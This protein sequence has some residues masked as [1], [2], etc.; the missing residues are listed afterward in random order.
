MQPFMKALR[1]ELLKT[2]KIDLYAD[3]TDTELIA[4]NTVGQ[5][6]T[7]GSE[8]NKKS[9]TRQLKILDGRVKQ[10]EV[11]G[12]FPKV[13]QGDF[14]QIEEA[15]ANFYKVKEALFNIGDFEREVRACLKQLG[16]KVSSIEIPPSTNSL[17]TK[18]GKCMATFVGTSFNECLQHG[19]GNNCH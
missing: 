7:W 14:C 5:G 19:R 18:M 10:A 9:I 6:Y 15:A 4:E 2:Y 3:Y 16:L 8:D 17:E 12:Y 1:A 13:N 11:F